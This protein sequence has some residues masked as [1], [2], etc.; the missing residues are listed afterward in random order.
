[1]AYVNIVTYVEYSTWKH[2]G[3]WSYG[4]KPLLWRYRLFPYLKMSCKSK[5]PVPARDTSIDK[6]LIQ[7][8]WKLLLAGFISHASFVLFA[9]HLVHFVEVFLTFSLS[10]F[11]MARESSR[12]ETLFDKQTSSSQGYVT[13]A[14]EIE[15]IVREWEL[16]MK[17]SFTLFT[18]PKHFGQR[19]SP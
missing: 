3:I 14:Y 5:L 6:V 1:M 16:Q 18:A 15:E 4:N 17:S 8:Y 19:V 13:K 2:E 7:V 9:K 11:A 10:P 12:L